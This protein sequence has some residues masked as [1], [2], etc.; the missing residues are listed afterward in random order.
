LEIVPEDLA[1]QRY[2]A[3]VN[4]IANKVKAMIADEQDPEILLFSEN[5]RLVKLDHVKN[6][7]YYGIILFLSHS[8]SAQ[9]VGRG[10]LRAG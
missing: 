8:P 9:S 10:Y 1:Y 3:S 7:F 6:T 5:Q 4:S 2:L